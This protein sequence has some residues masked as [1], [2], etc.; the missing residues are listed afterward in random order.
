MQF[1]ERG[2]AEFHRD[3]IMAT[4]R[5]KLSIPEAR[6]GS[7]AGGLMFMPCATALKSLPNIAI[8]LPQTEPIALV[9]DSPHSGTAYPADFGYSV[10]FHDLRKCEDTFVDALWADVPSV[11]GTLIHAHF[12]RSYIDAN[13]ACTDIDVAMLSE[14]WP[15]DVQ[16][17]ERCLALGN[18][19]VFSKTTT[20]ADIYERKLDVS[21]VQRR[22][23][24]CWKPYRNALG[25]ALHEVRS[26]F[27]R[28]WHLNLHSMP[29][30][31]YERLGLVSATPLADVVLG[32]L[33]G[34]SCSPRFTR[35]VTEAFRAL[36]Y[37]VS[38]NDPYAGQD[39]I[40]VHGQPAQAC[41]SL[42]I[43]LNRKLYLDEETREPNARYSQTRHDLRCVL[44][45][46][47][48]FIQAETGRRAMHS[49]TERAS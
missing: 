5:T 23:D 30:N 41:E 44:S 16:A 46:V 38:V 22:I 43:E 29:S 34:R 20:L 3:A 39:L 13:R 6:R 27:G 18:G 19:L 14:P 47:A 4:P 17:S 48:A 24:T 15:G 12:P 45:G 28:V 9:C 2:G 36:G 37:S 11:G 7:Y 10:A 32:D 35:C 1:D 31:A 33:Q 8:A 21:E 42:Q 40:R 49:E 25:Q 26:A